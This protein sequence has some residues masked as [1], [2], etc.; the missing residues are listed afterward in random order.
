[1]RNSFKGD[2][3]FTITDILLVHEFIYNANTAYSGYKNG[4]KISGI[5]YCISGSA[6]Y[7]FKNQQLLLKP[8]RI[9]FLPK[10][11]AYTVDNQSDSDFHHFTV[12]FEF[13]GPEFNNT[14]YE[15]IADTF[16]A[17][18]LLERLLGIWTEKK[19]GYRP[20]AKSI[21]YELL[22][23][24][25]VN[26]K[27]IY[28]SEDYRKISPAKRILDNNYCE[29]TPI[30]ALAKSCGFS[31][32]HFRRTFSKVFTCSPTQYRL[33][34]RILLAKELLNAGE[35]TVSEVASYVGFDDSSYFSRVFKAETG[36][37][38]TNYTKTNN[39]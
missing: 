32:T 8:G 12:N 35:L 15:A 11:S 4:R 17:E 38:P 39:F 36:T 9:L 26:V 19:H 18:Q 34:K 37:T 1:M 5:V 25:F 30:S 27:K 22:Y 33:K 3:D 24:Y 2:F 14:E 16:G 7:R 28:R 13:S 31:E 10:S 21:L 29:N 23:K 6:L 20:M